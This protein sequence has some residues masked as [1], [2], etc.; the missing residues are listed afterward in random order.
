MDQEYITTSSARNRVPFIG[1]SLG[2]SSVFIPTDERMAV[3]QTV[4]CLV[5]SKTVHFQVGVSFLTLQGVFE[6]ASRPWYFG[7]GSEA[8]LSTSVE[9]NEQGISIHDA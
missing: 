3:V 8:G 2:Y 9:F 5:Q 4:T 7:I 1:L 6:R